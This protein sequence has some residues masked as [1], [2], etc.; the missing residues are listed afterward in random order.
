MVQT[1]DIAYRAKATSSALNQRFRD[2]TG[3]AV[4]R[5]FR[6][7]LGTV[8]GYSISLLKD[9]YVS[10]VAITPSGVRVE[11]STDLL[12]VLSVDPNPST[13]NLPRVD[14]V[15]MV[16]EYG[17]TNNIATYTV[18]KGSD[19]PAANP[20]PETYLLLGYVYVRPYSVPLA[21]TDLEP[22]PYGFSKM[23]VAGPATFYDD[24]VFK[25]PVRFMDGTTGG[26][27]GGGGTV[28]FT[29]MRNTVDIQAA[30]ASF[31]TGLTF[32]PDI[33]AIF[34]FQDSLFIRRFVD[35]DVS[36]DGT[37]ITSLTGT[38][39]VD[40]TFDIIV[41]VSAPTSGTGGGGGGTVT[42]DPV[43]I[44]LD[45]SVLID[46]TG[47]TSIS[48]PIGTFDR[49]KDILHVFQNNLRIYQ[50]VQWQYSADYKSIELLDYSADVGDHFYFSAIS[51]RV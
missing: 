22:I 45:G 26:S 28:G 25:G 30:T 23:D 41:L 29:Q 4:L 34:V 18:V 36:D 49:T 47:I 35:Y 48:I 40:N 44:E 15:Y 32:D 39:D 37:T 9:Q 21:A 3:N 2:I 20:N 51:V 24:V 8:G 1:V 12:N 38:W 5:G 50:G 33:S 17:A 27:G 14:S 31:D 7:A 19:V 46:K 11:E 13:Q 10:S 16:Y 43:L 42:I 6:L